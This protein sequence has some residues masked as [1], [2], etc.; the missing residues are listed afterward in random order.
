[1]S[2]DGTTSA[3]SLSPSINPGYSTQ[4]FAEPQ[5]RQLA[6]SVGRTRA[7]FNVSAAPIS[8]DN[9]DQI[10]S[11][12]TRTSSSTIFINV[13]RRRLRRH[14]TSA[15]ASGARQQPRPR[16]Q[17]IGQS[18]VG[19]NSSP[20]RKQSNLRHDNNGGNPL[21]G[22]SRDPIYINT[23]VA[24]SSRAIDRIDQI[25]ILRQPSRDSPREL[26]WSSN[27]S[28]NLGS[29][30]PSSAHQPAATPILAHQGDLSFRTV[31]TAIIDSAHRGQPRPTS[32]SRGQISTS[33]SSQS[34]PPSSTP[35][36]TLGGWR[37]RLRRLRLRRLRQIGRASCRERVYVLV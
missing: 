14:T 11:T 23:T 12:S 24:Y 13:Q 30:Q 2:A 32:T 8:I 29:V 9:S 21:C 1:M 3:P 16:M 5:P 15:S 34:T 28:I 10:A 17:L 18:M 27:S 6:P 37:P 35:P 4:G 26:A 31:P 36:P 20:S 25:E 33:S 22:D 7:G 19:S